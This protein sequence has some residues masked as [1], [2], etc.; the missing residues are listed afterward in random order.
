LCSY[1]TRKAGVSAGDFIGFGGLNDVRFRG[2]VRPGDRLWL[3]GSTDRQ[4][5]RRMIFDVQG[6]VDG[7]MVFHAQ[8]IGMP[9]QGQIAGLPSPA[10]SAP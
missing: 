8:I 6:F 9:M 3:V 5:P 7:A 10:N 1:Y 4:S 2:M